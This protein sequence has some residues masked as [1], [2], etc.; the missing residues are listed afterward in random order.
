M[1]KTTL[2]GTATIDEAL[3]NQKKAAYL[4]DRSQENLE[5]LQNVP[6]TVTWQTGQVAR[7]KVRL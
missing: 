6:F 7:L 3:F 4:A 5:A 1:Q 2:K